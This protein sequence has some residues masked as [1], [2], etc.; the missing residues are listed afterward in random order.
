MLNMLLVGKTEFMSYSKDQIMFEFVDQHVIDA[1]PSPRVINSHLPFRLVPES[2]L[3]PGN[4]I[5]HVMRNPKDVAVSCY[6]HHYS[7]HSLW[8]YDGNWAAYLQLF[9]QGQGT[10]SLLKVKEQN[11][12]KEMLGESSICLS[13]LI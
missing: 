2:M 1:K 12:I 9:L 7:M 6:N 11:N 3:N 5:I 10:S 8:K 13:V 4:K